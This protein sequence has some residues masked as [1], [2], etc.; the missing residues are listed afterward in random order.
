MKNI[1]WKRLKQSYFLIRYSIGIYF[2]MNL[3][4]NPYNFILEILNSFI[5]HNI[6]CLY[7]PLFQI[8]KY[9]QL[10]YINKKC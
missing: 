2:W 6:T 3:L 9:N 4:L 5:R 1:I 10:F 8:N 7:S